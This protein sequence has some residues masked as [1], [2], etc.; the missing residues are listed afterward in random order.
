MSRASE[1]REWLRQNPGW[2]FSSDVCDGLAAKDPDARQK[3]AAA[4]SSCATR[5]K[6]ERK[7]LRHNFRYRGLA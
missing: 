6:I 7:G 5:K 2:H 3:I 1:C 4:L